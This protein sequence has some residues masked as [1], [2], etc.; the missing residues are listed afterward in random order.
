MAQSLIEK[1]RIKPGNRIA[2]L[3]QPETYAGHPPQLP[4]GV[5]VLHSL[6]GPFDQVH[7]FL[8]N[9]AE[10]DSLAPAAIGALNSDGLLWVYFPKKTSA[11][12]T[13]LSRDRG[14]DTI[15]KAGLSGISLISLD[16]TW[17][18]FA[19]RKRSGGR[20]A[21]RRPARPAEYRDKRY[22]DRTKRMVRAPEDL[23]RALRKNRTLAATFD[24]L[25]WTH[26]KE[27]VEWILAAKKAETRAKRVKGTIERLR[28]GLKNR[29]IKR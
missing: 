27:Y 6:Q 14:W 5:A 29:S 20:P 15:G 4:K 11:T 10:L 18:A 22:I 19:F 1:L 17:S 7:L 13:D 8:V 28:K 24:A 12:Q 25:A 26:K 9:R 23:E 16:E 21:A 3:N 2:V